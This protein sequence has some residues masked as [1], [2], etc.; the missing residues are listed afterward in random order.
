MVCCVCWQAPNQSI[1][2][3]RAGL[4]VRGGTDL[5]LGSHAHL[6]RYFLTTIVPS[7]I[8]GSTRLPCSCV[9][10]AGL[11][12]RL[13]TTSLSLLFGLLWHLESKVL[14]LCYL[15]SIGTNLEYTPPDLSIPVRS[16]HSFTSLDILAGP[17]TAWAP[18]TSRRMNLSSL[19]QDLV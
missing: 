8:N 5:D 2:F 6:F 1:T 18:Q 9:L 16:S 3:S 10:V 15:D 17:N 13:F 4:R 14:I 11:V 12:F 19:S 7:M